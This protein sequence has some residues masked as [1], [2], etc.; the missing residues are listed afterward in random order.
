MRDAG[1][2]PAR[3]SYDR[4]VNDRLLAARHHENFL[5]AI[6]AVARGVDG[7]IA[8]EVGGVASFLSGLPLR[9]FNQVLV[10]SDEADAA[11]V[12]A[13]VDA[14]RA[15]RPRFVLNLRVGRDDRFVALAGD[16]G[17][18]QVSS[19]PWL[20]AMVLAGLR[21]GPATTGAPH[22]GT[23]ALDIRRVTDLPGVDD[24]R[25]AAAA[26]FEMDRDLVD[27]IVTPA[28][29]DAPDTVVYVGYLDGVPVVSG[30]GIRTGATIG[31]YNIATVP[32]ARRRGFG[33]AM[34][35]WVVT[36]GAASGC[37]L[38]VLQASAM[39]RPIY[40]RLGF[41]LVEEYMGYVDPA[42]LG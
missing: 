36:D 11:A 33:A 2:R 31:I 5:A 3:G 21:A 30:L 27:R 26:G 10:A 7:A 14:A 17:L 4:P 42:T 41:R 1:S 29:L 22:D 32:A 25:R 9:L 34:T 40:E 39:G 15:A 16:L 38:A 28:I 8:S 35:S 13:A 23:P 12:E 24:H 6:G 19:D 37:D 18:V 20:P